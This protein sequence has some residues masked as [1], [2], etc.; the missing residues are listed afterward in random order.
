[1]I[2]GL[3]DAHAFTDVLDALALFIDHPDHF[4]F[5]ARIEGS[6]NSCCHAFSSDGG[7]SPY[8]GVRAN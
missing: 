1:M 2:G 4:Q 3:A 7:F 6:T 8:R 5:Q